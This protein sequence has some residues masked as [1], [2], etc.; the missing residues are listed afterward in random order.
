MRNILRALRNNLLVVYAVYVKEMK[1]WLRYPSWIFVFITLPYTL[2]GLFYGVGYAIAGG[3]AFDNFAQNTGVRDPLLYYLLGSMILLVAMIIMEDMGASIRSEQMRG[4]FE[5]H[6]LSPANKLLLWTSYVLPHG[7]ISFIVMAITL[8]PPLLW[9]AKSLD[10]LSALWTIA[11]LFI[12]MLPL[13][14]IGLITASLTIRFK[15]PWSIVN[16]VKAFISVCSGFLYP[17]TILP[18]WLQVVS[19]TIPTS[20]LIDLLR[21][22]LLFNKKIMLEDFRLSALILTSLFYLA[23]GFGVYLRW[24]NY[25]RKT[26]D[27][28]KY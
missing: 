6:Y 11:L 14:G 15:E 1:I 25:A 5:L 12:G 8:T 16:I 19:K 20:Y 4:T 13:Y 24:E 9:E 28:S 2:T 23:L 22:V 3:K 10:I 26:G 18:E 21:D 17:L 27:L 7:T